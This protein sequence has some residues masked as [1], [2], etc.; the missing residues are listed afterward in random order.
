MIINN[1]SA[2]H[3]LLL[4]MRVINWGK[5]VVDSGGRTLELFIKVN[6]ELKM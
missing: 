4:K 2:E 1:S 3:H 5:S 6:G